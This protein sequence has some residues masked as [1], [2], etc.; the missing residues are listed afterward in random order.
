MI[1]TGPPWATF[2]N[3]NST[4]SNKLTH[5]KKKKNSG[6][7]NFILMPPMKA[8]VKR[9]Y[10]FIIF[11]NFILP[12]QPAPDATGNQNQ[13]HGDGTETCIDR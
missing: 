3:A 12:N 9:P 1:K 13:H 8:G 11:F 7:I 6:P 4:S 2:S 10:S 5:G